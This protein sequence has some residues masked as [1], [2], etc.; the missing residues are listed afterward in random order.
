MGPEKINEMVRQVSRLLA[1][2]LGAK[3]P[4][5]EARVASR[6][7]ALPR[8]VRKAALVLIDA[9]RKMQAPK[10][11]RQLDARRVEAA[12]ATCRDYLEPLGAAERLR[13]AALGLATSIAVIVVI[14][15]GTLLAAMVW[16]GAI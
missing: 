15:G 9:E 8:K 10:I 5:L 4:T 2:R 13:S 1:Q 11:A 12:F 6:A 3:G 7:R 16:T 14:V